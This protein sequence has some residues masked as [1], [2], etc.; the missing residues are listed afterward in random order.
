MTDWVVWPIF[1]VQFIAFALLL[2]KN[3]IVC[4]VSL[5]TWSI[6]LLIIVCIAT[7]AS[8]WHDSTDPL[9]LFF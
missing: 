2:L 8:L 6:T 4:G 7:V 9:H 5:K 3:K 1:L